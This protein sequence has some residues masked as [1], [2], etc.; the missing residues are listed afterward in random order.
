MLKFNEIFAE[1]ETFHVPSDTLVYQINVHARLF[2]AKFVSYIPS[3]NF[4]RQ[5]LTEINMHAD[6]FGTLE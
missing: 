3:I 4:K 2:L 1:D 5:T 6:L